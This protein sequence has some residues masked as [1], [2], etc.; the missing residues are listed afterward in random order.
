MT[1]SRH[2]HRL[3][4][5]LFLSLNAARAHKH[6]GVLT[7]EEANA[8]IDSILW[9]H[10]FLQASVWGVLFPIGMVLGLTRSRWHV[11]LQVRPCPPRR[12]PPPHSHHLLPSSFLPFSSST[13]S[14]PSVHAGESSSHLNVGRRDR[15]NVGRLHTWARARRPTISSERTWYVCQY[16][17]HADRGA[18]RAGRVPQA[19]HTRA[20]AASLG[21]ARAWRCRKVVSGARMGP[22]ALW[23]DRVPRILS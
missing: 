11:P 10:I 12:P 22:D 16:P 15:A 1:M 14:F 3:L 17:P 19:A 4:S 21:G 18:A 9:I 20:D 13:G 7:E 2:T 8:P 5:M 23:C 6:G